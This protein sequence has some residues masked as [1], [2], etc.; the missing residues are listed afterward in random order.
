MLIYESVTDLLSSGL[1]I[2]FLSFP[3]SGD[4]F[5]EDSLPVLHFLY[6]L[7]SG[8]SAMLHSKF[9]KCGSAGLNKRKLVKLSYH[10]KWKNILIM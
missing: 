5:Y 1:K 7:K 4:E 9:T 6:G 3:H 10:K 2:L 8:V